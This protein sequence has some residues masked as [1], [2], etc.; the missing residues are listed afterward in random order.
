MGAAF[1]EKW[2]LI[3]NIVN[4]KEQLLVINSVRFYHCNPCDY[5]P[6]QGWTVYL[7]IKPLVKS[8]GV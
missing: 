1:D 3:P 8:N 5:C 2:G 6:I 4:K 7:E